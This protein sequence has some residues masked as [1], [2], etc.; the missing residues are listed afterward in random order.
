MAP[1]TVLHLLL[2]VVINQGGNVAFKTM[3]APSQYSRCDPVDV[4][5]SNREED[6]CSCTHFHIAICNASWLLRG[7]LGPEA[8]Q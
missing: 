7:T 5:V 8:L 3:D 1:A 6:V 2:Y 4:L